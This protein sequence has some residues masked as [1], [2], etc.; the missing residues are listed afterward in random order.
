MGGSLGFLGLGKWSLLRLFIGDKEGMDRELGREME[1]N[2][3]ELY[4]WLD[5]GWKNFL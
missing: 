2:G 1:W 4:N 3:M 5:V